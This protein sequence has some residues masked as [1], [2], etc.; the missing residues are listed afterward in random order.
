VR[1]RPLARACT[2]EIA[3]AFVHAI[4]S[5][6]SV[7]F[8]PCSVKLRLEIAEPVFEFG[9]AVLFCDLSHEFVLVPRSPRISLF[10][11]KRP[12]ALSFRNCGSAARVEPIRVGKV[13]SVVTRLFRSL[14]R[15]CSL[16]AIA[17][18]FLF[19]VGFKHQCTFDLAKLPTQRFTLRLRASGAKLFEQAVTFSELFPARHHVTD[20]PASMRRLNA[21]MDSLF[22]PAAP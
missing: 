9:N 21:E 10:A 4:L 19:V 6:L 17:L 8:G 12:S 16:S 22:V 2:F 7:L 14:T 5:V 15:V 13:E 3:A 11:A 18:S 1:P 20:R